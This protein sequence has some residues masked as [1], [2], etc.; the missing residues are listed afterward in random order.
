MMLLLKVTGLTCMFSLVLSL[1]LELYFGLTARPYLFGFPRTKWPLFTALAL[2]WAA[3][4]KAA[5]YIVFER[6]IFYG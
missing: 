4:F 6:R 1:L 2:I 5:Y 3:S